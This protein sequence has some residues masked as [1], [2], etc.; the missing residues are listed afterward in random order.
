MRQSLPE[1]GQ[2]SK[3]I[4]TE[5][6]SRPKS[7]GQ[8]QFFS[9]APRSTTTA[10]TRNVSDVIAHKA[11]ITNITQD[12]G[13]PSCGVVSPK[14]SLRFASFQS[15]GR[16]IANTIAANKQPKARN[17]R[18]KR[19]LRIG[20]NRS[21]TMWSSRQEAIGRAANTETTSVSFYQ[22]ERANQ[23][24]AQQLSAHNVQ[25]HQNHH[26]QQRAARQPVQRMQ[27]TGPRF[28]LGPGLTER[29][30]SLILAAT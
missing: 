27:Q 15:V 20:S 25:R 12:S 18:F 26:G 10:R 5:N 13:S 1:H 4:Q 17:I 22:L 9:G 24:A 19:G 29:L 21:A 28:F 6:R 2:I 11:Q 30:A 7:F 8:T 16:T 3:Q 23:R 14:D